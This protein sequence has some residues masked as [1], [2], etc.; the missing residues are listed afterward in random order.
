MKYFEWNEQKNLLLKRERNISFE[1]IVLSVSSGGLLDV[2]KHPD[3][4]KYPDQMLLIVEVKNYAYVVPCIENEN[5]Y[6]LKSIY[7]NR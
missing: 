1:D 7:P 2:L 3:Q 4:D 5:H 6:F